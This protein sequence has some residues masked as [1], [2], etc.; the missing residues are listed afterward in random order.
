MI[1]ISAPYNHKDK[2]VIEKRMEAVYKKFAELMMS[3][4]I[5]V[6]PLM[7]HAVIERHPVPLSSEFWEE[8]SITLLSK[9]NR[10]VVLLLDGWEESTGV[11]YEIAYCM[12]NGISFE[13]VEG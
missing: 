3:G 1:Y 11:Q 9:C 12:K 13:Y 4:H 2:L 10:M 8:Y 5:P 7:A 6:T